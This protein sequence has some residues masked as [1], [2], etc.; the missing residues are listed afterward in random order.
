M[1][2]GD[3]DDKNKYKIE[4]LGDH[5]SKDLKVNKVIVLGLYGVGKTCIIQKLMN[6]EVYKEYAPTMNIDIKNF[7]VK[8]NDKKIQIQIWDVCGKDKFAQN[9]PNLFKNTSIAIIV[10]AI[11]NKSS[12]NNLI[13]WYNLV[14]KYSLDSII[15]LIGNKS[16][17][18]E[19][20]REVSI[21]DVE[22]FKNNYADNIN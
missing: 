5:F 11:N 2:F 6:K 9:M 13:N 14:K 7:Q 17:L 20:T 16:D 21:E 4:Y 19:K 22:T 8:V 10:Y 12:F 18:K 1:L 3:E 15:F